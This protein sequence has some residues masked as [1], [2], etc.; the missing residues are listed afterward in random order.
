MMVSSATDGM[1]HRA[2]PFLPATRT[3]LEATLEDSVGG[4]NSGPAAADAE[5]LEASLRSVRAHARWSSWSVWY[6]KRTRQGD[7]QPSE[8][9]MLE[10]YVRGDTSAS[11]PSMLRGIPDFAIMG[12]QYHPGLLFNALA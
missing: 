5:S 7:F 11:A 1:S 9:T 4:L 3:S 2:V 8:R 12:H 6:A 10:S